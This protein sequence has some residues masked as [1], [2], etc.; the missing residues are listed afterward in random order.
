VV[1]RR[2]ILISGAAVVLLAAVIVVAGTWWPRGDALP[3]LSGGVPAP[4]SCPPGPIGAFAGSMGPT[5]WSWHEQTLRMMSE[6]FLACGPSSAE[7]TY[8]LTWLHSFHDRT[9]LLVSVSRRGTAVVLRASR[10]A[11]NGQG[12]DQTLTPI[13]DVTRTLTPVEWSQ[14]LDQFDRLLVLGTVRP[15]R[16]SRRRWLDVA[17]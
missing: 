10:F 13:S 8:R 5:V 11:R 15:I 16:R 1:P 12:A 14:L 4:R 6:P 2:R 7:E 3:H 9:P 17:G